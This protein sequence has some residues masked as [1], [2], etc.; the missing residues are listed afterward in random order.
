MRDGTAPREIQISPCLPAPC[1]NRPGGGALVGRQ[2][3]KS[4]AGRLTWLQVLALVVS[5]V[6]YL[7]GNM[8]MA[9]VFLA[10]ATIMGLA[11]AV[12]RIKDAQ[13]T[14][15]ELFRNLRRQRRR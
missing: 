15:P 6:A 13:R 10:F 4:K 9:V 2:I 12:Y 5:G 8:G 1:Y 7:T 3:I 11:A 14:D